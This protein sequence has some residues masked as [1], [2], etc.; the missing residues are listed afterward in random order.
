LRTVAPSPPQAECGGW[1]GSSERWSGCCHAAGPFGEERLDAAADP[2]PHRQRHPWSLMELRQR[3]ICEGERAPFLGLPSRWQLRRVRVSSRSAF[4]GRT[5]TWTPC[6]L[7]S[8]ATKAKSSG[9]SVATSRVQ[10]RRS[11]VSRGWRSEVQILWRPP[12]E[13]VGRPKEPRSTPGAD[14][15]VLWRRARHGSILGGCVF[16]RMAGRRQ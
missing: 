9:S 6:G 4:G 1:C 7:A 12:R 8:S 11:P 15:P 14:C 16:R 5:G 2:E 3:G 13:H 10:T